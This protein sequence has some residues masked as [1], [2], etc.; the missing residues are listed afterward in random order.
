MLII[1]I[2]SNVAVVFNTEVCL[3]YLQIAFVALILLVGASTADLQPIRPDRVRMRRR[4]EQCLVLSVETLA[5]NA[6]CVSTPGNG[7]MTIS[8]AYDKP[9]AITLSS[10]VTTNGSNPA[11]RCCPARKSSLN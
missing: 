6:S 5:A 8:T 4:G 11:Q 7:V 1:S 3:V 10:I 9:S 2:F